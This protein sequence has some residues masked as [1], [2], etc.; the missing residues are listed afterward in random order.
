MSFECGFKSDPSPASA[1]AWAAATS[2][3]TA[4]ATSW[5]AAAS[6][7]SWGTA[8][9]TAA[10][11]AATASWGTSAATSRSARQIDAWVGYAPSST[12][13]KYYIVA[14]L[15]RLK[16]TWWRVVNARSLGGPGRV[17][18]WWRHRFNGFVKVLPGQ[19][20]LTCEVVY[21]LYSFCASFLRHALVSL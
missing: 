7:T 17:S 14:T 10:W 13:I 8:A 12:P 2:W 19:P 4:T 20:A 16:R 15:S 11:G 3:G 6:A 5:G 21:R 1:A 18:T 9:A